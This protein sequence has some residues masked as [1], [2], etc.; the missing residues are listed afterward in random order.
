MLPDLSRNRF[1]LETAK[2][3]SLRDAH[4][5]VRGAY[6]LNYHRSCRCS[7]DA[8][9]YAIHPVADVLQL[10]VANFTICCKVFDNRDS[11]SFINHLLFSVSTRR[12]PLTAHHLRSDPY[13]SIRKSI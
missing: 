13:C 7:R 9:L 2:R 12:R 6:S 4:R 1:P 10:V 3:F 5:V 8:K 11:W